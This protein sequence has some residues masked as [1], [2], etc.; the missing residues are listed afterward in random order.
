MGDVGD[1]TRQFADGEGS[2]GDHAAAKPHHQHD[3]GIHH[4]LHQRHGEDD[5]LF[6]PHLGGAHRLRR[7]F[8][9]YLFVVLPYEGLHHPDGD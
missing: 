1:E 8:K 7:F 5:Q 6:R 4:D 9:F 3:A 2:S